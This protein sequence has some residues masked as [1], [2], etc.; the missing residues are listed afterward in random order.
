MALVCLGSFGWA[1]RCFFKRPDGASRMIRLTSLVGTICAVSQL[2]V[3]GLGGVSTPWVWLG[4]GC[5]V[6]SLTAFYWAVAVNRQRPLSWAYSTDTPL[7]L[8][9]TGPYR[10]VR[11]PFYLSYLLTFFGGA[12]ATSNP[13][14]LLT[15]LAMGLGAMRAARMEEAKFEDSPLATDYQEYRGRVGMFFPRI[16]RR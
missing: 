15:V 2:A 4:W 6:I 5:Y 14:L 13:W 11:H 12:L 3:I 10:Y 1:M 9:V 8:Q 16:G 7:H